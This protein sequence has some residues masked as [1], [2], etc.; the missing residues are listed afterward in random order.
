MLGIVSN[1]ITIDGLSITNGIV[2][3]IG[4]NGVLYSLDNECQNLIIR[5]IQM[6]TSTA[7]TFTIFAIKYEDYSSVVLEKWSLDN[8]SFL[9]Q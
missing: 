5:N 6:H 8:L 4:D 9:N 7:K 2:S 3:T 1:D